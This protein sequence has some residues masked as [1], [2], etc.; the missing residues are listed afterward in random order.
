MDHTVISH[1]QNSVVEV[2]VT[3]NDHELSTDESID[4]LWVLHY[5]YSYSLHSFEVVNQDLLDEATEDLDVVQDNHLVGLIIEGPP[6][7]LL[8]SGSRLAVKF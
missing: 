1:L 6:K 3:V 4:K 8:A 2:H 5:G 7:D